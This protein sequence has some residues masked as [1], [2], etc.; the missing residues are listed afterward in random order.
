[1]SVEKR[2]P[3]PV[4]IDGPAVETLWATLRTDAERIVATLKEELVHNQEHVRKLEESGVR[5]VAVRSMHHAGIHVDLRTL[6]QDLG[7]HVCSI[8]FEAGPSMARA[9]I[10]G[11][12]ADELAIFQAPF[13]LGNEWV[14]SF[15]DIRRD[16]NQV[17]TFELMESRKIANSSDCFLRYRVT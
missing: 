2:E 14:S 4:G 9:L 12:H 8:L 15:G 3:S 6:F 17:S 7:M 10:E 13:I 16:P 11:H 1:M 5:V